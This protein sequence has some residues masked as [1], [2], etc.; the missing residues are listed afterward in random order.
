MLAESDIAHKNSRIRKGFGHIKPHVITLLTG[1]LR[2]TR[3]KNR[4]AVS[5]AVLTLVP[6]M[7]TGLYAYYKSSEAIK[8]K[9]STYSIQITNQV[10]ENV[11]NELMKLENDSVDIAFSDL[12]QYALANYNYMSEW[13]KNDI[14]ANLQ[15]TLAKRFSFSHSVSDVLVYTEKGDKLIAYGDTYFQFKLRQD[16]LINLIRDIKTKN[17]V[18]LWTIEDS[19]VEEETDNTEYRANNYGKAGIMIARSFKSLEQDFDAGYIIIRI[20]E[21]YITNII[22]DIN[23]GTGSSLLILN[24]DGIVI[25]G[26]GQG[27]E[28]AKPYEN[29]E[30]IQTLITNREN[31]VYSF[32][33]SITGKKSLIAYTYIPSSDWYVVSIIPFSYLNAETM[34]I[35]INIAILGIISFLLA[36]LV[37]FLVSRSISKPLSKLVVS[38][39][40]VKKGNFVVRIAD[41]S[42]DELGEMTVHF[43]N[44]VKEIQYLIEEVKKRENLKRVAE[45]KALQAQISPHF[46][47]NTLNT[48]RWLANIQNAE[49]ISSITKS[50]IQLLQAS[51]GKGSELITIREEVQYV[52]DY[53]NIMD[54]RYYDKFKVHF[55]I[56][57]SIMEFKILRFILQPIVENSLIHGIEPISG[58]GIIVLKGYSNG[59]ELHIT[60]TDNGIGIP[61]DDLNNLM[62]DRLTSKK[63]STLSGIGIWNV[64]E[65]IKLYFGEKYGV[66]IE[67]V[68]NLFT[69]VEITI[70]VVEGGE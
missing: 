15:R 60:I 41:N 20:D 65:R 32:N 4:L 39:N 51:M 62:Q 59:D 46:L 37:S 67:S 38:M 29:S 50:L 70:P 57:E 21:K 28:A 3:I 58:Q 12:V 34:E 55:E 18:P 35:G 45:L 23:I 56:E 44:M 9:I 54:Y 25:S 47:S 10:S 52:K 2:R 11:K 66:T 30:L 24:N 63:S 43:N 17:G 33:S 49:N 64:D 42:R 7:I 31:G 48:V 8:N 16:Y 40:N 19:N 61:P 36:L 27:I 13:E 14:E 53:L 5:F 6:V 1:L 22:K 26:R 68:P 69:A